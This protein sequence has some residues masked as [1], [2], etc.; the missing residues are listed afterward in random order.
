M[1]SSEPMMPIEERIEL[2]WTQLKVYFPPESQK[3]KS[4]S[5]GCLE[6][7]SNLV[8]AVRLGSGSVVVA[9]HTSQGTRRM[10]PPR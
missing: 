2:R 4:E 8:R 10:R 1:G 5:T 7:S 6:A 9:P 3:V